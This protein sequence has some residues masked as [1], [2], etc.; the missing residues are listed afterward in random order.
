MIQIR[1]KNWA[2]GRTAAGHGVGRI[3]PKHI[4]EVKSVEFGKR[5]PVVGRKDWAQGL[6]LVLIQMLPCARSFEA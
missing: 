4:E 1:G 2:W 3:Q 6:D 5:L